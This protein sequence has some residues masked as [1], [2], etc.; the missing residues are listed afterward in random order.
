MISETE[1][2]I[3]KLLSEENKYLSIKEISTKTNIDEYKIL[4]ALGFLKEK[5][6]IEL[7]EERIKRYI[8][9]NLGEEYIKK[10]LP[11]K[12]LLEYIKERKEVGLEELKKIFKSDELNFAL[13][14]LR[15]NG[16][17]KI[18]N[19][20]VIYIKDVEI[21]Q[22]VLNKIKDGKYNEDEIKEF[23]NRKNIVDI[24]E[25]VMYYAKISEDGLKF[26]S[27]YN[28]EDYIKEYN[29]EVIE[30]RL[31]KNKK[32]KPYDIHIKVPPEEIGKKNKYL[33]FL[34]N[35]RE[36]LISM[37]FEEMEDYNM[38]ISHF[39]DLDSLFVPQDHPA[40]DISLMDAY[41]IKGIEVLPDF[42]EDLLERVKNTHIKYFRIFDDKAAYKPM[43]ISH[44]TAISAR[45]LLKAKK[46]GKYFLIEKVFRY[47][48]IDAK[49]FIEFNQLEGIILDEDITFVDLLGILKDLIVNVVKAKNVKFYPA[50]FPFTEPS[51]EIYAEHK[52]LGWIEVGGAGV[53]REELLK[54]FNINY[55]VLAWGIGI[56][57]LAM[58]SLNIKDIRELHTRDL[59]LKDI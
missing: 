25:E 56:D 55:P 57:R 22:E 13:G 23:I 3:L 30:K 5:K 17:V 7:K 6:L 51:V 39:W 47:D 9:T 10:G 34:D 52:E 4:R 41:Y 40:G 42:P 27:S 54:P 45:T 31:Y 26:L 24:K 35:I 19:G 44:I 58:I 38:I 20:K 15:K 16:G 11:E 37:G 59:N 53:F 28:P 33:L 36:E 21:K 1:Y 12:R 50:F 2:I 14:Y 29:R 48:T 18:E 49:H 32:F 46:P 43:L 8:L